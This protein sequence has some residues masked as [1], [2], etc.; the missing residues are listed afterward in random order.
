LL[1]VEYS[2][3]G[4][5]TWNFKA[6]LGRDLKS[7]NAPGL[8]PE[9]LYQWRVWSYS[10]GA[11]GNYSLAPSNTASIRPLAAPT[12]LT[13]INGGAAGRVRVGWTDNSGYEAGDIVYYKLHTST[14]WSSLYAAV[15]AVAK[16]VTGLTSGQLYDFE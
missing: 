4:G 14:A 16:I 1:R 11:S 8:T 6:W 9:T 15:N 13:L 2:A 7:Y 10:Y 5:A 12:G 3:D